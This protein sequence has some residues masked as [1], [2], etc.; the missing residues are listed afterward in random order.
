MVGKANVLGIGCTNL[1]YLEISDFTNQ[2]LS[3]V[4]AWHTNNPTKHPQYA[5]LFPDIPSRTYGMVDGTN[6]GLR[7][8]AYGISI[9]IPGVQPFVNSINMGLT[10]LT[11]DCIAYIN[12]LAII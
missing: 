6:Q 4:L 11:S 7:S 12:K 5:I 9:G 10:D 8:V 2:I 1:E 3:Q